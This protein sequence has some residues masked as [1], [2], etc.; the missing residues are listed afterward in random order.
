LNY[1]HIRSEQLV[2]AAI[3]LW[4]RQH[5]IHHIRDVSFTKVKT[6]INAG[7]YTGGNKGS[8]GKNT[9]TRNLARTSYSAYHQIVTIKISKNRQKEF[10]SLVVFLVENFPK[11][12]KT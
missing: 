5:H 7:V 4:V 2:G 3:G 11:N 10:S 12:R 1:V 6:G 8:V 9:N